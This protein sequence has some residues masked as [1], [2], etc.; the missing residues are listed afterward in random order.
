MDRAFRI[1]QKSDVEV[2]RLVGACE[3][4]PSCLHRR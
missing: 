3:A 4:A 2:Y 1:G